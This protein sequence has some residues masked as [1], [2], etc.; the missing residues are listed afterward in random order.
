MEEVEEMEEVDEESIIPSGPNR[1]AL[2]PYEV[3]SGTM[4]RSGKQAWR[5]G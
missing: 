3:Q 5:E 2:T 4:R 1:T